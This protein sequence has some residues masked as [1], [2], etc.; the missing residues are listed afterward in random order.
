MVKSYTGRSFFV[1][2][3][4]SLLYVPSCAYLSKYVWI[5]RYTILIY[6]FVIVKKSFYPG[7]CGRSL[8]YLWRH[9]NTDTRG[10][11]RN[12]QFSPFPSLYLLFLHQAARLQL[13]V[14]QLSSELL[15]PNIYSILDID[16]NLFVLRNS[17]HFKLQINSVPLVRPWGCG[18]SS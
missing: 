1:L 14:M 2:S 18:Y 5:Y 16:L 17:S 12:S 9:R 4:F 3:L 8:W 13:A 6:I 7:T 11:Y 10:I 15:A